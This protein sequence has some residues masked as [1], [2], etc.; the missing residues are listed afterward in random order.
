[1]IYENNCI[2][3]RGLLGDEEGHKYEVKKEDLLMEGSDGL[4]ED[5]KF[6]YIHK[7]KPEKYTVDN[8]YN[9]EMI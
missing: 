7:R 5:H 4:C 3:Y 8:N 2:G 9:V 1:M 6:M